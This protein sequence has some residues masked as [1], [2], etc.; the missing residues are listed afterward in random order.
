MYLDLAAERI[1]A[2]DMEPEGSPAALALAQ[3]AIGY[4]AFAASRH[5]DAAYPA[6]DMRERDQWLAVLRFLSGTLMFQQPLETL[7]LALTELDRGIIPDGLRKTG[8]AQGGVPTER[9]L[10]WMRRAVEV[11]DEF[12]RQHGGHK[13][14]AEAFMDE[15]EGVSASTIRK[16]R[17]AL[18]RLAPEHHPRSFRRWMPGHADKTAVR[19][20]VIEEGLGDPDDPDTVGDSEIIKRARLAPLSK[21]LKTFCELAKKDIS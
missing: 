21:Q 16:W 14:D 4:T 15:L 18:A 6:T 17:K 11:A 9:K 10:L 1:A 5:L 12:V 3:E 7:T 20:Y 19:S 8:S 13:G 2:A